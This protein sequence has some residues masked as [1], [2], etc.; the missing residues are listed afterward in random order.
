MGGLFGLFIQRVC[1][2][3][4][5][6][7]WGIVAATMFTN[8]GDLPISI[9]LAVSDH[10]PFLVGDGARGTAYSSVFIAVFYVFLFPL[11]GFRLIRYDHVK[12]SKRIAAMNTAQDNHHSILP[13]DD[14][15]HSHEAHQMTV[16]SQTSPFHLHDKGSPILQGNGLYST[17]SSTSTMV[18]FDDRTDYDSARLVSGSGSGH[19]KG[20]SNSISTHNMST[21]SLDESPG[22]SASHSP[23]HDDLTTH[24]SG[25]R[26]P[27]QHQYPTYSPASTSRAIR[28]QDSTPPSSN[29]SPSMVSPLGFP[30]P[31]RIQPPMPTI[32][33]PPVPVAMPSMYQHHHHYHPQQQ[34]SHQYPLQQNPY[35]VP[36]YM[37]RY[38]VESTSSNLTRYSN[39]THL[40]DDSGLLQ[41][42]SKHSPSSTP[43]SAAGAKGRAGGSGARKASLA[44]IA[45]IRQATMASSSRGSSVNTSP[46]TPLSNTLSG[47]ST[48]GSSG[49]GS[50]SN[51]SG[52]TFHSHSTLSPTS[53]GYSGSSGAVSS[54]SSTS[55]IATVAAGTMSTSPSPPAPPTAEESLPIMPPQLERSFKAKEKGRFWSTI[56]HTTREY[57]TP[58]TIGLIL[59]LIVALTPPLRALFVVTSQPV[60]SFDELPPLSFIH[61]VTLLLGGCCVPLGLTVLGA[62]LSRLKPGRWRPLV[63]ALTMITLV[64]LV[65]CPMVGIYLV[66]RW[67]VHGWGIVDVHNHMLQ[68]TLMLMSGSPT[69]IICFVLAQVWDKRSQNAGAEMAAVI[70]VQ[71]AAGTVL[72]TVLSSFMMYFLFNE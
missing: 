43:S 64:K 55:S 23:F 18:S 27:Q 20:L 14:P 68:F 44:S 22:R 67:L 63:P 17:F 70:A 40:D 21:I 24:T 12:E 48:S 56:F 37:T 50:S 5:R 72:I 33:S 9:I 51:D 46:T 8:F 62:S 42:S 32:V 7:Y 60:P 26:S 61:E 3:P 66:Q 25:I 41:S 13:L 16:F 19:T 36:S 28:A 15:R 2:V 1:H 65:V 58:P 52:S 34:Q 6:I 71:Y 57:L 30:S 59:G 69:S 49:S 10:P 47:S 31:P 35:G 38:S 4:K 45:A 39:H 29:S 54:S 11:G 53:A